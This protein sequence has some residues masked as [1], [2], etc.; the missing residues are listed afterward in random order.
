MNRVHLR[1]ALGLSLL[2]VSAVA[3]GCGGDDDGNKDATGGGGDGGTNLDATGPGPDGGGGNDANT[4]MDATGGMDRAPPTDGGSCTQGTEGCPCDTAGMCAMGLDCVDWPMAGQ[5]DPQI[6]T[7]VRT[8]A[9]EGECAMSTVG[10]LC[11]N[12][13]LGD[14]VGGICVASEVAV[15]QTC[16]GSKRVRGTTVVGCTGDNTCLTN[17]V[18]GDE[19]VCAQLCVVSTSTPTGGCMAPTPYCSPQASGLVITSTQG[20]MVPVGVCTVAAIPVGARCS[21]ADITRACDTATTAGDV[22]CVG[23][24]G[25]PQGE[26]FCVEFCRLAN[27]TCQTR[28]PGTGPFECVPAIPNNMTFGV[29]SA[30]CTQFPDICS[31]RGTVGAGTTCSNELAFQGAMQGM[32]FCLENQLPALEEARFR[33]NGATM[34]IEPI[35]GSG[36]NCVGENGEPYRCP[37]G[38]ACFETQAGAQ[39][40]CFRGCTT[41]TAANYPRGGCGLNSNTSTSAICYQDMRVMG[42]EQLCAEP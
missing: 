8:C 34:Q 17:Q 13:F 32:T 2:L 30:E 16:R 15:G 12:F 3:V 27:N 39:G 21:Q 9:N 37:D 23:L 6:R 26:G 38:T 4:G 42:T 14:G 41:S 19:G 36:E 28:D 40:F 33:V 18:G 7:C 5:N 31:G 10:Q 11:S 29:C 35:M 24:P 20:E 22:G 1:N 25:L